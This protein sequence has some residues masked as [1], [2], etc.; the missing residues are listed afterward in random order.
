MSIAACTRDALYTLRV[1]NSCL[2]YRLC[3]LVRD[4]SLSFLGPRTTS[5]STHEG[6]LGPQVE[7][8]WYKILIVGEGKYDDKMSKIQLRAGICIPKQQGGVYAKG[9]RGRI[10]TDERFQKKNACYWEG[11]DNVYIGHST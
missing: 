10:E 11:E 3:V 1:K 8:G 6:L 2:I 5:P 9:K 7:P 4:P